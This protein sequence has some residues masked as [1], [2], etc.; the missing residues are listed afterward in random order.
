MEG[1]Y[2][3]EIDSMDEVRFLN[4]SRLA[5]PDLDDWGVY[6]TGM[7]VH[8]LILLSHPLSLLSHSFM[9]SDDE[10][11]RCLEGFHDV[12]LEEE[13]DRSGSLSSCVYLCHSFSFS[14]H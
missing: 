13:L 7:S 8:S 1:G 5:F 3:L 10:F 2:L 12:G 9:F 11:V 14:P 6:W 4:G